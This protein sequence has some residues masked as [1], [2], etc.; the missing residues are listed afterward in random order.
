[1]AACKEIEYKEKKIFVI[2]N[3]GIQGDEIIENTTV[4]MKRIKESGKKDNLLLVDMTGVLVTLQIN[5]EMTKL[6]RK[7]LRYVKK[8]AIVGMSLGVKRRLIDIFIKKIPRKEQKLFDNVEK[9]KEWLA[10]D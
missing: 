1:M 7:T 2:D 8:N 5:N 10:R 9:A 3:T 6:G 4:G